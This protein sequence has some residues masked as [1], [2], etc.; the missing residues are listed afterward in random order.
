M[1]DSTAGAVRDYLR[2]VDHD[3]FEEFVLVLLRARFPDH[4]VERWGRRDVRDR[5]V[6][7]AMKKQRSDSIPVEVVA[8]SKQAR[9]WTKALNDARALLTNLQS[10]SL[11]FNRVPAAWSFVSSRDVNA[12][13]Q[14]RRSREQTE[15]SLADLFG[16]Q[17]APSI[18]GERDLIDWTREHY[19]RA[20]V[21]LATLGLSLPAIHGPEEWVEALNRLCSL[22]LAPETQKMPIVGHLA[23]SVSRQLFE[24]A[25]GEAWHLLIGGPGTGKTAVLT[26]LVQSLLRRGVPVLYVAG[27]RY[28][29]QGVTVQALTGRLGMDRPLLEVLGDIKAARGHC[30]IV[31]DQLEDAG[32]GT[33]PDALCN[34]LRDA[35]ARSISVVAACQTHPAEELSPVAQMGWD[36]VQLSDLSE[37]QATNL[38]QKLGVALPERGLIGLARNPLQ[39]SWMAGLRERG[40]DLSQITGKAQL[41]DTYRRE[42]IGRDETDAGLVTAVEMARRAV[43]QSQSEVPVAD[44]GAC[45]HTL[46]DRGV[47]LRS[48]LDRYALRH[49]D[50]A[51][52]LYAW[53][54][55]RGEPRGRYS[56]VT[57]RVAPWRAR[58]VLQWMYALYDTCDD[59]HELLQ[60]IADILRPDGPADHH[61]RVTCLELVKTAPPSQDL[62]QAIAVALE[63]PRLAK[64]FYSGLL[65]PGWLRPLMHA[66][67]FTRFPEPTP[68]DDSGH[69]GALP[70]PAAAYL[71][72]CAPT[73]PESVARVIRGALTENWAALD[74]LAQ[75]AL[76]LPEGLMVTTVA[77][78]VSWLDVRF[79]AFGLPTTLGEMAAKLATAGHWGK[80]KS[81]LR[82]LLR[83]VRTKEEG[84][85]LFGPRVELV[86]DTYAV[87]DVL[88]KQ[89]PAIASC[90]AAETALLLEWLLADVSVLKGRKRDTRW[91]SS[92]IWRERVESLNHGTVHDP[93]ELLVAGILTC[94]LTG[95]QTQQP[96]ML[97]LLHRYLRG[98]RV[99]YILTRL[100]LYVLSQHPEAYPGLVTYAYAKTGLLGTYEVERE[101]ALFV[102]ATF[103]YLKQTAPDLARSFV[104]K[105]ASGGALTARQ[106]ANLAANRI[107]YTAADKRRARLT[108]QRD[109]LHL[110]RDH[111]D[112][113]VSR[114]LARL[115]AEFG[116]P[117]NLAE[118]SRSVGGW[119]GPTSPYSPGD[120]SQLSVSEVIA[121]I[122]QFAPPTR[123][124]GPP[125]H[126]H[127]GFAR[128]L[129]A[130][131]EARPKEYSRNAPAFMAA[132]VKPAYP[133]ALLGGLEQ[134]IRKGSAI[135][136]A[137]VL[138]LCEAVARIPDE[139]RLPRFPE[140]QGGCHRWAKRE[141][142]SLIGCGMAKGEVGIPCSELPRARDILIH[143]VEN[144]AEPTV[145][146]ERQGIA[147]NDS[148]HGL[149]INS[150]RSEALSALIRYAHHC[151]LLGGAAERPGRDW[152][153][154]HE[155]EPAVLSTLDGRLDPTVEPSLA[156]RSVFGQ[157][158]PILAWLDCSW[159]RASLHKIL[160]PDDPPTELWWAAWTSYLLLSEG[161]YSALL[162]ALRDHYRR[163]VTA[164]DTKGPMTPAWAERAADPLSGHVMQ[165]LCWDRERYDDP[166]SLSA[167][168]FSLAPDA[169]RA[170]AVYAVGRWLANPVFASDSKVM[171]I[172]RTLWRSR[173]TVAAS[174]S[175]PSAFSEEMAAY[176]DWLRADIGLPSDL[177]DAIL[178]ILPHLPRHHQVP[179]LLKYLQHHSDDQPTAV[180]ILLALLTAMPDSSGIYPDE[181]V[182]EVLAAAGR[183]SSAEALSLCDQAVNRLAQL[184]RDD[185]RDLLPHA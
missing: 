174:S 64:A 165:M 8:V 14:A 48:K 114:K 67:V 116:E 107:I 72:V 170:K 26:S 77:V 159:F 92:H 140:E 117:E 122:E 182:R 80:V 177:E 28:G 109:H 173:V 168:F 133:S 149:A 63:D 98:C 176:A 13:P 112:G 148:P 62:A 141:I 6:D 65:D 10:G 125:P 68:M 183:S 185:F 126:S 162:P 50:L 36:E 151:A 181:A 73:E 19:S 167:L 86:L 82:A 169:V 21:Q 154:W 134:A 12:S 147:G 51:Y 46:T 5:G 156:V 172:L 180:R 158:L 135:H 4:H 2:D 20:R 78:V 128:A 120:L 43:E 178:P 17:C 127:E 35:R 24:A 179:D 83:T 7:I 111:L 75:V 155:M 166:D 119:V 55:V 79:R 70:W 131:A 1:P 132:S 16:R 49:D 144:S 15:A 115:V 25:L 41:W 91:D 171:E 29:L 38:L 22:D 142:A 164:L 61:A 104:R 30:V 123:Q 153:E 137:P 84:S 58:Q 42:L 45:A 52:Y 113:R 161:L 105:L 54:A 150:A 53:Q 184:G 163:A 66:G 9:W 130:D 23:R 33:D 152:P 87:Q 96:Q 99:P 32:G 27:K 106:I 95:V 88:E 57:S 59:R 145:E 74:H 101:F 118:P 124:G 102:T 81:I 34:L 136:W 3:T 175:E 121:R 129:G 94:L 69:Y 90:G 44:V 146:R 60:F 108:W 85:T 18:Y 139:D 56:D 160:P 100:A 97:P 138:E 110:I 157:G 76:L 71:R 143:L 31:A 11:G 89:L 40:I 37:R 103:G 93:E 39:L 47:L